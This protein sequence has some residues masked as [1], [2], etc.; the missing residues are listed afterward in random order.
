MR[1]LPQTS[2]EEQELM[3]LIDRNKRTEQVCE[4]PQFVYLLLYLLIAQH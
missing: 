4:A 1:M 3:T 2:E